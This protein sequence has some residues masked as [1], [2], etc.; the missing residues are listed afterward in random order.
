MATK[1]AQSQLAELPERVGI[2]E[3][4]VEAIKEQIS[5]LKFDVKEMH[6]CLDK[7]RDDVMAELAKMQGDYRSNST[8]FFEHADKLHNEDQVAQKELASKVSALEQFKSKWVYMI[9]GGIA[10]FGFVSG[11]LSTLANIIK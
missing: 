6:D 3:T 1:L 11:H 9:M 7:T 5:D 2:V 10:V 8:K 4:K